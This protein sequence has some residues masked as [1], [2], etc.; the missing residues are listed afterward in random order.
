M[1]R[2]TRKL[3]CAFRRSIA[4]DPISGSDLDT[5]ERILAQFVARAY[6]S[7]HPDF[8]TTETGESCDGPM[9]SPGETTSATNGRTCKI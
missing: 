6:A 8:F 4:P 5:V 9:L 7:D 2:G 3:K 1:P